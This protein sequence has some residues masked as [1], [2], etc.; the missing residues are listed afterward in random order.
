[1]AILDHA[2][3]VADLPVD[4]GVGNYDPLPDGD[5]EVSVQKC[6][7]KDTKDGTGNY[8]NL[9]LQVTEGKFAKRVLFAM[10]T[11]K[12]KSDKAE[13]IGHGQLRTLMES[14]GIT[15][16]SDTDQLIGVGVSVRVGSKEYNGT[17]SNEVKGWKVIAGGVNFNSPAKP[18]STPS[19][20]APPWAAKK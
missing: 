18:A 20:A 17:V 7:L 11:R 5:Y 2:I 13:Q 3:N 10:I 4:E 1:M 12:N 15:T 14:G 9:Q 6:E 16:L 8:F 19:K